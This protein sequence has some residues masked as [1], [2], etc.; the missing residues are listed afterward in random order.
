MRFGR[1]GLQGRPRSDVG[2]VGDVRFAG[3]PRC[4]PHFPIFIAGYGAVRVLSAISIFVC[5]VWFRHRILGLP[6]GPGNPS[7]ARLDLADRRLAALSHEFFR[8]R[9]AWNL[10]S[11]PLEA[12]VNM[13]RGQYLGGKP[14]S[15]S[16]D[17]WL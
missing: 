7:S 3:P 13:L 1:S 5:I 16:N 17:N 2:V 14:N 9:S 8:A 11:V 12:S 15:F 4:G 10:A 6:S